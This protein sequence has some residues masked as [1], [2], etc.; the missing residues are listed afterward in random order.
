MFSATASF[1]QDWKSCG[2]ASR[3]RRQHQTGQG[4]L[5]QNRMHYQL[6]EKSAVGPITKPIRFRL[7]MIAIAD[8]MFDLANFG[9]QRATDVASKSRLSFTHAK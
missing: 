5:D 4:N 8:E 6:S 9:G 7:D 2:A 3:G 1:S